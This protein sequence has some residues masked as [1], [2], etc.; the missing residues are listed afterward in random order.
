MRGFDIDHCVEGFV[1]EGQ[2]LRVALHEVQPG[3]IVPFSAER[4]PGRVEVQPRIRDRAQGAHEVRS[5]APVAAT[6]LKDLCARE[7]RLG[8]RGVVE[9]D[10]VPVGLVG[11]HERQTHRRILLIAQIEKQDIIRVEPAG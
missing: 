9:L 8:R 10:V 3:Q 5:A 7:I 1:D 4:N 6:D 2:I 11:R